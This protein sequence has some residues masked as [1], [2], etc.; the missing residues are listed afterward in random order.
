MGA[1]ARRKRLVV[2]SVGKM[3]AETVELL[4]GKKEVEE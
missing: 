3:F 1:G 2:G 4:L